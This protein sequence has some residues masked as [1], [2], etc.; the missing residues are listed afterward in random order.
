MKNFV[1]TALAFVTLSIPALAF[2][3]VSNAQVFDEVCSKE[4]N[5]TVCK[6]VKAQETG[7]KNPLF[8][9]DGFITFIINL[10]SAIVGIA[11]VI[12]IVLAGF[13]MVTSG[14]NPQ[15]VSNAREMVIYAIAGV[16]IAVSAQLIVRLFLEKL[17]G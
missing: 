8:G 15:D 16:I 3:G 14:S 5:S 2:S 4:P 13:K 1:T 9:P 10:M 11:S 17:G 6:E 12:M 7:D